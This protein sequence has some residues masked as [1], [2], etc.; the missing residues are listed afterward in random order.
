MKK[1]VFMVVVLL[2]A[3]LCYESAL[4][5]P[6]PAVDKGTPVANYSKY[7]HKTGDRSI[8]NYYYKTGRLNAKT[9]VLLALGEVQQNLQEAHEDVKRIKETQTEIKETQ[10]EI[11]EMQTEIKEKQREICEI[12]IQI[13]SSDPVRFKDFQIADCCKEY[14]K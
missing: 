10:T 3:V 9:R 1:V 7:S 12:T 2:F 11:K 14:L 8:V 13:I 4:N 6:A 5:S